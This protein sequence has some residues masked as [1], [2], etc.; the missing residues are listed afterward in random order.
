[1]F[2]ALSLARALTR[3]FEVVGE[4]TGRANFAETAFFIPQLLTDGSGAAS[5]EFQ[6]PDSVTAW[7]VWAHAVTRDLRGGTL[8][9]KRARVVARRPR[10]DAGRVDVRLLILD[11][12]L[13]IPPAATITSIVGTTVTISTSTDEVSG[14]FA[15]NDFIAGAAVRIYDVSGGAVHLTT[16][17]SIL[18]NTQIVVASAPAFAIQTGVDYVV[19]SPAASTVGGTSFNGYSMSEFATVANDAGTITASNSE[20]TTSPRWR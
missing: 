2:P 16:V 9:G 19:L 7:N 8:A 6:V 17:S 11:P 4:V 10:Y 13:V 15:G 1:M 12:L 5:F 18:S 14:A 20:V 3:G